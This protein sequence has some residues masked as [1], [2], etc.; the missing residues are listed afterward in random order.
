MKNSKALL[1][2]GHNG[3]S[4][5]KL[6]WMQTTKNSSRKQESPE[7]FQ[8]D[9]YLMPLTGDKRSALK[10]SNL[11]SSN[12]KSRKSLVASKKSLGITSQN[13]S[14][15][16]SQCMETNPSSNMK[17]KENYST[18]QIESVTKIY[19]LIKEE[20]AENQ[21]SILDWILFATQED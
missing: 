3:G 7:F 19:P 14:S 9:I 11:N 17:E 2:G 4:N 18:H 1:Q 10:D 15:A 12:V 21:E 20:E 6:W 5:S 16:L 8:E 13:L